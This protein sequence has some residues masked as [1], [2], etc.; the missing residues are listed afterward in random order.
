[1]GACD[2]PEAGAPH[3]LRQEYDERGCDPLCLKVGP[4][5]PRAL[6]A[7]LPVGRFLTETQ[8]VTNGHFHTTIA[9]P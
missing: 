2:I 8:K 3:S 9:L 6:I 4:E 1:M 5:P 7:R